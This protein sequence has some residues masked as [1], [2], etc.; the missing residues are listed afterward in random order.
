M[1]KIIIAGAGHGGLVAA[2]HFA[3]NGY[4]VTVFEK[5]KRENLGHDWHDWLS[6]AAFDDSG[7]PRPDE[8]IVHKGIPSCFRNPKNSINIITQPDEA[9]II[10]DRKELITFLVSLAEEAGAKLVFDTEILAPITEGRAVKGIFIKQG[11]EVKAVE[12][13]LLVDA[14]GMYSPIR[15]KLPATF[16]I[17]NEINKRSIFHV[18]RAYYE[19]LTGE[20]RDPAY[21]ID[22]F[23]MY[24][25]GLDWCI[26]NSDCVDIL[27]GKFSQSG[28]LT[29]QEVDDALN[30]YKLDFPF[31]GEKIL[32]GGQFVD[33]PISRMLAL[34]VADGY[35]AIGDS[36]G[37]TVPLNGS[38]IILSM[39]AGKILAD[40]VINADG[41][42]SKANLWNYEYEYF[43]KLGRDLVIIDIVKTVFTYVKGDVVD[44]I[45]ENGILNADM[46][47]I[48][49][50]KPVNLT[51]DYIINAIKSSPPLLKLI[52]ALA[53]TMKTIPFLNLVCAS[54]PK[55]Y[56]EEKVNKWIKSYKAL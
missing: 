44:Y 34:I 24:R 56:D 25:P 38:G 55:S 29:Q 13:D 36:A 18:Y 20:D 1:K 37:M 21:H 11:D 32:R 31:L 15:S 19:N 45:M 54:I 23:H 50:G 41:D 49:D 4:D 47:G 9:A 22:M 39:N 7:I 17:D 53:K 51:S 48:A 35:A 46:L 3:K 40:T 8:S 27:I 30:S 52:P 16:N 12:G 26:T 43:N 28:P 2:T 42:T 10:M 5:R 33:I 6:Y 14:A